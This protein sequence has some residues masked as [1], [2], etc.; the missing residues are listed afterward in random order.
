[1][2]FVYVDF[3]KCG[4]RAC[5][6][7]GKSSMLTCEHNCTGIDLTARD[8]IVFCAQCKS[9]AEEEARRASLATEEEGKDHAPA[10]PA[11]VPSAAAPVHAAADAAAARRFN[12]IEGIYKLKDARERDAI[13]RRFTSC[14]PIES[15]PALDELIQ[16]FERELEFLYA[17][18]AKT[19]PVIPDPRV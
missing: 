12:L 16:R 4:P 11:S 5:F 13:R 2:P 19:E 7:D 15:S 9:K 10:A 1:M 14:E 17:T 8:R 18:P 3:N 6:K